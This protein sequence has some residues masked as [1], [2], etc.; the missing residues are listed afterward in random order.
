MKAIPWSCLKLGVVSILLLSTS[1][2]AQNDSSITNDLKNGL[3]SDYFNVS[4]LLQTNFRYSI[5]DD[6][7]LQHRYLAGRTFQL[8]NARLDIKGNVDGGYFYRMH[9]N[10]AREP[11]LLDAYVGYKYDDRLI[12]TAGRQKPSQSI[13]FIPAPQ[14]YDFLDRARITRRLVAFRELGVSAQGTLGNFNYYFGLFNG[15]DINIGPYNRFYGIGRL[16][17]S[18]KNVIPG[19]IILGVSGSQGE[20]GVIRES[21]FGG[22]YWVHERSILGSD[23]QIKTNKWMFKVEYLHS[24]LEYNFDEPVF[25]SREVELFGYYFSAG[26]NITE[27]IQLLGRFQG[28]NREGNYNDNYQTT[29]GLKYFATP[30]VSFRLN[31]DVYKPDYEDRQM[32]IGAMM[33]FRF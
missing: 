15:D 25:P 29:L 14:D 6:Y 16:Q 28:W 9:F 32:G 4:M 13:D 31:L 23:I 20:G 26:Y 5:E 11:N 7:H 10:V 19:E 22:N 8:A 3:K 1:L 2:S 12:I 18:I 17:Y 33:Q 21:H 30:N 24:W 27:K